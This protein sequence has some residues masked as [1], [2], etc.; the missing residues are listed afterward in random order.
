M[1]NI[2]N[3]QKRR[4]SKKIPR[5]LPLTVVGDN[6]TKKSYLQTDKFNL[7]MKR[8]N[9]NLSQQKKVRFEN[10]DSISFT[11]KNKKAKLELKNLKRD[12]EEQSDI[13]NTWYQNEIQSI[14]EKNTEKKTF[15]C[16]TFEKNQFDVIDGRNACSSISLIS[17]YN[18][19]RLENRDV[20]KIKWNHV[21]ESG[22]KLWR[23]WKDRQFGFENQKRTYQDVYEAYIDPSIEKVR[24]TILISKEIGGHMDNEKLS[25][26]IKPVIPC[27]NNNSKKEEEEEICFSS[28]D[29][30]IAL[31]RNNNT[32]AGTFTIRGYSISIFFDLKKFWIFDSHGGVRENESTLIELENE[33][34]VCKY[35]RMKYP[36]ED[37][38][39]NSYQYYSENNASDANSFFFI[40]FKRVKS[41]TIVENTLY[42]YLSDNE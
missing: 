11:I 6:E 29:S 1:R 28:L 20:L 19:L 2:T 37:I 17:V 14:N 3:Y 23:C 34:D 40:L 38:N 42:S 7:P 22:A 31:L 15:K 16:I 4:Q 13:L 30:A 12:Y 25:E 10:N 24:E 26:F 21:I 39:D 35:I 8:N 41:S 5:Y 18:F 36:L 9:N 27:S 33:N 32:S